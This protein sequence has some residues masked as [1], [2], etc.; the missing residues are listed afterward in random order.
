MSS[1][2]VCTVGSRAEGH[3]VTNH[4]DWPTVLCD[5]VLK[6]SQGLESWPCCLLHAFVST[7]VKWAQHQCPAHAVAVKGD[8]KSTEQQDQCY[9][10]RRTQSTLG[11]V[12][13][14]QHA[15]QSKNQHGTHGM[16][17]AEG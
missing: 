12:S 16:S 7:S 3:E 14:A 10:L 2:K 6:S 5:L 8:L 9:G 1:S 4:S 13:F 11:V 17:V 15:L